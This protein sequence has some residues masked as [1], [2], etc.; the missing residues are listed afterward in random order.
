M[1]K[2]TPV[3]AIVKVMPCYKDQ[4]FPVAVFV[5]YHDSNFWQQISK[6][7]YYKKCAEREA[8]RQFLSHYGW[9]LA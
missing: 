5:K 8:K 2:E 7:Y 6:E 4:N 9:Q 1:K 3:R